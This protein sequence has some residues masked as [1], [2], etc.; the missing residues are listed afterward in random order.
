MIIRRVLTQG[1][2][3]FIFMFDLLIITG[4]SH[5]I[6]CID[7]KIDES[8]AI[9]IDREGKR[10][11]VYLTLEDTLK[12]VDD[13]E[14]DTLL[15]SYTDPITQ[16]KQ[17]KGFSEIDQINL[18]DRLL[19]SLI[20]VVAGAGLGAWIGIIINPPEQD[21]ILTNEETAKVSVLLG[22]TIGFTVGYIYGKRKSYTFEHY[23]TLEVDDLQEIGTSYLFKIKDRRI[24]RSKSRIFDIIRR[25]ERT[26]IVINPDDWIT[27]NNFL[28]KKSNKGKL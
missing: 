19:G 8:D 4:C 16:E 27:I 10:N 22:A 15:V 17:S 9:K 11:I 18:R 23:K 26:F 7:D 20:G 3:I 21:E 12:K 2:L 13:I 28:S 6:N 5:T 1:L 24:R 14:L 25:G